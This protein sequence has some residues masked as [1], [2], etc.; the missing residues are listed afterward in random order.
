MRRLTLVLSF[1]FFGFAQAQSSLDEMRNNLNT[2]YYAIAAQVLGPQLINDPNYQDNPEAYYLYANALFLTGNT[3]NARL[4]LEQAKTLV[5][6]N[7]ALNLQINHLDALVSA[8]EGSISEAIDKLASV[9]NQQAQYTIAMDWGRIAWQAGRLDEALNAFT[10]AAETEQG[11]KELW[12]ELN[13]GRI[14][15]IQGRAQAAITAFNKAIEIFEAN[16]VQRGELPSPGYIEA[17]Y[18]LASVYEDLGNLEEARLNYESALTIGANYAPAQAALE[19]LG[20][21]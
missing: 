20:F 17:Y 1:C 5:T 4:Y 3:E 18:Q 19:R 7:D 12:P 9:F 15:H 2:G 10:K 13:K 16:D 14:L 21:N 8:A 6:N 11:Q